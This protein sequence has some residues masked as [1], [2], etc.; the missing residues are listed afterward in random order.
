[1]THRFRA[2]SLSILL[3]SSGIFWPRH[4]DAQC[5]PDEYLSGKDRYFYYCTKVTDRERLDD[6]IRAITEAAK[7]PKVCGP[8]A[9]N[10][11]VG[12]IGELRRIPYCN[13]LLFLS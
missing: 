4:C 13:K 3:I 2:A 11:F 8:L 1:M 10:F 5:Y 12:K 9:C 6:S 7:D